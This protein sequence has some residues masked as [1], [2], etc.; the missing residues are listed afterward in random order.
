[1]DARGLPIPYGDSFGIHA[2]P[3]PIS[4]AIDFN[5]NV[6]LAPALSARWRAW[7]TATIAISCNYAKFASKALLASASTA[8]S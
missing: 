4:L 2:A 7:R 3:H 1:M 8:R 6:V 5:F